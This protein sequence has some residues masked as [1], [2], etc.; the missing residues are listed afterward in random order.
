MKRVFEI[1]VKKCMSCGGRVKVISVITQYDVIKNILDHV[2]L[3]SKAPSIYPPRG[4]L[5]G[6][7]RLLDFDFNQDPSFFTND[8]ASLLC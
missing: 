2:G 3:P 6:Q 7:P 5:D 4:P 1:D 8:S